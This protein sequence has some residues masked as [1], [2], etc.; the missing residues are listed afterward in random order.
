MIKNNLTKYGWVVL[1]I[2]ITALSILIAG[3]SYSYNSTIPRGIAGG[4]TLFLLYYFGKKA[5]MDVSTEDFLRDK[6]KGRFFV[7]AFIVPMIS[8]WAAAQ[9]YEMILFIKTFTN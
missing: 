4:V 7:A 5:K 9:I 6:Q 2:A 8:Y 3:F 1:L